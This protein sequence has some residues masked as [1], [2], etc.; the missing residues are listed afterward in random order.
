[1]RPD[2]F[3][4]FP[5]MVYKARRPDSGGPILCVDPRDEAWTGRNQ[6]IVNDESE[7]MRAKDD[8]W[9]DTPQEAVAHAN[10]LED[11]IAMAAA[12]RAYEDK[13]LSEKARAEAAAVDAASFE[14]VPEIPERPLDRMAKARAAK[15]AKKAQP[16]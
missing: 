1:M 13:R 9:R 11:A 6:M 7:W 12:Q 16:E 10:A 14:H 4:Q 8:G 5:K 15:A 2:R 3:M